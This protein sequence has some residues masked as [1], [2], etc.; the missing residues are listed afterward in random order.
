[1]TEVKVD[2]ARYGGLKLDIEREFANN[3]NP[4]RAQPTNGNVPRE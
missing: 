2:V 3:A 4:I 1:M